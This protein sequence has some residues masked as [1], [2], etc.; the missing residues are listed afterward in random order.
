[1]DEEE[2]LWYVKKEELS[3]VNGYIAFILTFRS[4]VSENIC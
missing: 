2:K 4:K 1:M 3:I